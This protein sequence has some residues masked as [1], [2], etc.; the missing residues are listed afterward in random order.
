MEHTDTGICSKSGARHVLDSQDVLAYI[1]EYHS[2]CLW[3][4]CG[5]SLRKTIKGEDQVGVALSSQHFL[6]IPHSCRAQ[7]TNNSSR[8]DCNGCCQHLMMS[9]LDLASPCGCFSWQRAGGAFV[10]IMLTGSDLP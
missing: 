10:A 3:L 6:F 1:A 5:I 8:G 7:A 2:I 4:S 9:R